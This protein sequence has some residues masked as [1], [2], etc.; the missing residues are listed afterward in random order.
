MYIYKKNK[1][2]GSNTEKKQLKAILTVV[3]ES[4]TLNSANP[5]TTAVVFVPY[6]TTMH[7]FL[8]GPI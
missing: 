5:S 3:N 4:L 2:K 7:I 1:R 8:P 6:G